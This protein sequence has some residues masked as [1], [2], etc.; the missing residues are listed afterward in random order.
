[1]KRCNITPG[2]QP[3]KQRQARVSG[4]AFPA[5][6]VA[7]TGTQLSLPT[8]HGA[9]TDST[10]SDGDGKNK[11]SPTTIAL[12]ALVAVLGAG[13]VALAVGYVMRRHAERKA[14]TNGQQY[15]QTGDG[16]SPRAPMFDEK[17]LSGPRSTPYDPP[18]ANS[19]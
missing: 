14:R 15:F 2:N 12:I 3:T 10:D 13:Y 7:P 11:L 5:G 6:F 19:P 1:M 8:A 17:A 18:R 4:N 16:F 9:L